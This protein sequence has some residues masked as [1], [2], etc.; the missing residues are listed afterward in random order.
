[1]LLETAWEALERAG[2]DPVSLRGSRTGTYI[3]ATNSD[4]LPAT[5]H[6]PQETE[7][8]VLTG[9][10]TSVVSGRVAYSL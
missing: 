5:A 7:G 4:Y 1:V 8:Y 10:A 6:W 2:I 3:G 9:N